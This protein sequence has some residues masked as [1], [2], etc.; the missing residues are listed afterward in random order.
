MVNIRFNSKIFSIL[1]LITYLGVA[2]LLTLFPRPILLTAEPNDIEIYLN[3]HD[4]FLNRVLYAD[5]SILMIGN[6]LF[7]TI[8]AIIF[9]IR[10]P[11]LSSR[12]IFL[13][14][15]T[16]SFIIEQFQRLIPGRVSD[17]FDLLS[18]SVSA[19]FGLMLAQLFLYFNNCM[20]TR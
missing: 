14:M 12:I 1:V 17:W 2:L 20:A 11:K 7:L 5:P 18:N 4:D 13:S 19:L 15:F 16:F 6:F 3:A 10:F 8:P 9:K